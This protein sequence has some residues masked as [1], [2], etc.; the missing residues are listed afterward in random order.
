MYGKGPKQLECFQRGLIGWARELFSEVPL[1]LLKDGL[2]KGFL[3]I[4]PR[5]K[6]LLLWD[7]CSAVP[8]EK[9]GEQ[10]P[11]EYYATTSSVQKND[12]DFRLSVD[13]MQ[14]MIKKCTIKR[15]L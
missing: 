15:Q 10:S 9:I 13:A 1:M 5:A 3:T 8:K 2:E 4:K 14:R 7:V 11:R 6:R 12:L